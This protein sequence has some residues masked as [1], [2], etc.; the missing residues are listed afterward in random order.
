MLRSDS[1][2]NVSNRR[3]GNQYFTFDQACENCP[4]DERDFGWAH[5]HQMWADLHISRDGNNYFFAEKYGNGDEFVCPCSSK[6]TI[7]NDITGDKDDD[8]DNVEIALSLIVVAE[9]K[10]SVQLGKR[11]HYR[12]DEVDHL[13]RYVPLY[14]YTRIS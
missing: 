13:R 6:F 11:D 5:I 8:G 10:A 12:G 7:C 3:I 4:P 14:T 2:T 9:Q 1:L